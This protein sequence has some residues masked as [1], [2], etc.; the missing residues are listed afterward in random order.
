MNDIIPTCQAHS[1]MESTQRLTLWLLGILIALIL[2]VGGSMAVSINSIDKQVAV[3]PI[4]LQ[5]IADNQKKFKEETQTSIE[6]IDCRVE[7]L[8]KVIAGMNKKADVAS[9]KQD[10]FRNKQPKINKHWWN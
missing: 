5:Y 4:Q 8:E 10:T 7:A 1:G 6:K 2:T 9:E 3:V